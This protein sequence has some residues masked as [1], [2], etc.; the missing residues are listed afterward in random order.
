MESERPFSEEFDEWTQWIDSLVQKWMECRQDQDAFYNDEC[1]YGRSYDT[2]SRDAI[3][4]KN[5][6]VYKEVLKE[7]SDF[8]IE[9]DPTTS[10]NY[11]TLRFFIERICTEVH[12]DAL[13]RDDR[14][15]L[16]RRNRARESAETIGSISSSE[17]V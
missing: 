2:D 5:R 9:E 16:A 13:M 10:L 12:H 14:Q 7:I 1:G 6:E 15:Q 3:E 8:Q 11:Q 4:S 17:E